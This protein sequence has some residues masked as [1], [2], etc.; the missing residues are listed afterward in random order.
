MQ[1]RISLNFLSAQAAAKAEAELKAKEE[2]EAAAA[3]AAADAAA[4][5]EVGLP[6]RCAAPHFLAALSP[7]VLHVSSDGG[8]ACDAAGRRL[9]RN[10]RGLVTCVAVRLTVLCGTATEQRQRHARTLGY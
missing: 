3:K 1:P 5:A 8:W 7:W 10:P 2:A 4:A 9:S 6:F